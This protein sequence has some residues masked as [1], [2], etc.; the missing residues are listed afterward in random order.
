MDSLHEAAFIIIHL[1]EG[2]HFIK[3]TGIRQTNADPFT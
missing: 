3:K 2:N 1:P